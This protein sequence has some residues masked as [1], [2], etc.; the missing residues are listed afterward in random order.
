MVVVVVVVGVIVVVIVVIA[1][2]RFVYLVHC[3]FRTFPENR[4]SSQCS[5]II[6][7]LLD[8][9]NRSNFRGPNRVKNNINRR[10]LQL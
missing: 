2:A 6:L 4:P 5:L 9:Q 1:R 8:N 10:I 7:K 3:Q